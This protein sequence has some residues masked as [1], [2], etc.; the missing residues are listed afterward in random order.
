[1]QLMRMLKWQFGQVCGG[2][3]TP[4]FG[5]RRQL[6]DG[7]VEFNCGLGVET[8]S[9]KQARE[10]ASQ[11]KLAGGTLGPCTRCWHVLSRVE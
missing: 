10:M 2:G 9:G 1:M 3:G 6:I 5:G 7:V 8:Q 4:A 11:A